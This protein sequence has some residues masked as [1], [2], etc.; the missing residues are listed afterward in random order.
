MIAGGIQGFL[1]WYGRA[2]FGDGWVSTISIV[3]L[4]AVVFMLAHL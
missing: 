4:A 2:L 3:V 1:F